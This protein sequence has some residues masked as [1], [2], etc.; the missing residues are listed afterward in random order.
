MI[1]SKT[2]SGTLLVGNETLDE[3]QVLPVC[4]EPRS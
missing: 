3:A 1:V 2:S 4:I